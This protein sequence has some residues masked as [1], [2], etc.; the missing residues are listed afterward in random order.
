MYLIADELRD[1]VVNRF[2]KFILFVLATAFVSSYALVPVQANNQDYIDDG[3]DIKLLLLEELNTAKEAIE[4]VQEDYVP[5]VYEPAIIEYIDEEITEETSN[6]ETDNQL[7]EY[8]QYF[9]TTANLRLRTSPSLDATVIRTVQ[10]GSRV[11]VYNQHDGEWFHV[12]HNGTAGYMNSE[13]LN[14][15]LQTSFEVDRPYDVSINASGV[16][17]LDWDTVRHNIVITGEHLHVTDVRTGIT[18]WM[19]AFSQGNHADVIPL[20]REDTEAIRRAFGGRWSWE[21]RAV[22]VTTPDGRTIAASINGMPH[23]GTP[24]RENGMNGHICMHFLGSRT[25]NGNRSHERDHQNRI[26]EAF[27]AGQ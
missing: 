20:T 2:A 17:L 4:E 7:D 15:I 8:P 21:P 24:N 13:F 19:T 10:S 27:N 22:W 18:F 26:Q 12:S 6:E 1:K 3:L 14:P 11:R 25:H 23:A 9:I 5:Q 16:E